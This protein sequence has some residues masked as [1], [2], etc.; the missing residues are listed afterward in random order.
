MRR[1]KSENLT[2]NLTTW[3]V[4]NVP[5]HVVCL[6]HVVCGIRAILSALLTQI[7]LGLQ[8]TTWVKPAS[9]FPNL[10]QR[11]IMQ[12]FQRS[13]VTH[14]TTFFATLLKHISMYY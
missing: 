12:Q 4:H 5:T 8:K 9:P 6:N 14:Y 11:N 3:F 10:F 7:K 1:N 2:Y 13:Y